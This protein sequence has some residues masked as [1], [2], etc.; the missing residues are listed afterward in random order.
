ML[1]TTSQSWF[2]FIFWDHYVLL[3][4]STHYPNKQLK[5]YWKCGYSFVLPL[6]SLSVISPSFAS[7]NIEKIIVTSAQT[8]SLM[9]NLAILKK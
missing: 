7:E 2:I 6:I 9:Y 5:N 1:L 3:P 8:L 4:Q